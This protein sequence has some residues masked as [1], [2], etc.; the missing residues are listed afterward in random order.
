MVL[1]EGA[2]TAWSAAW[3][4]LIMARPALFGLLDSDLHTQIS[5]VTA[6]DRVAR[7]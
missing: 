2:A 1:I 3:H 5:I 6:P 4:I 7:P